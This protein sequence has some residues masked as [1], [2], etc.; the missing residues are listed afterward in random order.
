MKILIIE[1]EENLAKL[2][3]KGLESEGYAVDYLT[4]GESGENRIFLHHQDYDLIILDLM[5]PL[6]SGKEICHNMREMNIHTPVL[7]LTAKCDSVSKVSLLDIG[8]DDY[9]SKP[10][11]LT[12]LLARIR[13]LTR[14]P[15]VSLPVE[16]KVSDLVLSPSDKKVFRNKKDL[17]LTLKEFRLLEYFMRRPNQV[18]ERVNLVDNIWDFDQ[19]SFS[20]SVDVYINRLRNKIDKGRKNKLIQTIRGVGYKLKV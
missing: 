4:D 12:E 17:N 8:A 20:N 5:L 10:F 15:K 11:E 16:L 3:K 6:K 1:D 2:I 7:V 18:I 19:N 14:R 9:M 13:A